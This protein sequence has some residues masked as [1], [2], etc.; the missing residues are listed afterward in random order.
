MKCLKIKNG[1]IDQIILNEA[2]SSG[3]GSFLESFAKSLHMDVK[4][5]AQRG[6]VSKNPVDLGSRCTV[7]M[8]SRVKQAQKEGASVA[9]ISAGLA[10]SVVK[11]ALFKVIKL[12]DVSDL[13]DHVVV[14]GG[15][16]YNDLVLRSFEKLIG[17]N[18]TRPDIAGLM[19][20]FGCAL[21]S[22][23]RY[24]GQR[25]NILNINQLNGIKVESSVTR[26][27]GCSNKCLL[28]INKF[29]ESE[30]FVSGNRCEV[31][32]AIYSHK[33]IKQEKNL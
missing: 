19:G 12:R 4:D 30:I 33:K 3:C 24:R 14:Q 25:S 11:N 18:V 31:G 28:T 1:V 7:F 13:G 2:C 9:D 16:F 20:A 17:R 29:S 26:C 32:E 23:E 27:K 5:F 8:N 6:I 22:K 15:T 21:I 10:Y